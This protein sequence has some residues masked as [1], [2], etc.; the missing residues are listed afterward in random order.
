MQHLG[1]SN[2]TLFLALGLRLRRLSDDN[3]HT[4]APS[5]WNTTK[6]NNV[7]HNRL[8]RQRLCGLTKLQ[9]SSRFCWKMDVRS[10]RSSVPVMTAPIPQLILV[11]STAC[12]KE[13]LS[14][15]GLFAILV[16][17]LLIKMNSLPERCVY[18]SLRPCFCN[19][20][21]PLLLF[22]ILPALTQFTRPE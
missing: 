6:P 3:L 21:R 14:Y 1:R 11:A 17:W 22:T 5:S 13:V 20:A 18:V 12:W 16:F 8:I 9:T 4:S 10:R 19:H 15:T 2:R 7:A